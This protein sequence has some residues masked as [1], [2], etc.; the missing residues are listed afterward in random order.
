MI[1]RLAAVAL[2]AVL[3]GSM[4]LPSL[5]AQDKQKAQQNV[6]GT[7]VDISKDKSTITVRTGTATRLVSWD[8]NTKFLYGHSKDAKAGSIGAVK[9]SFYISCAASLDAKKSLTASECVY[10]ETK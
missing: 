1:A 4:T 2:I 3:I 6:Q 9:E 5:A 10:R 8:S 7:V